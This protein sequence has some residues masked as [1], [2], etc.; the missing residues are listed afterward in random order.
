M[1]ATYKIETVNFGTKGQV[2]IPRRLRR[3]FE[4]EE[5][6][7]AAVIATPEGILLKPVTGTFIRRGRGILKR[8]P[9]D[10]P[11]AEEWAGHKKQERKLEE[12]HVR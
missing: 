8:K 6:T 7:K 10:K 3:E 4:I 2:V 12:R 5:G 1:I 11:L 9:G